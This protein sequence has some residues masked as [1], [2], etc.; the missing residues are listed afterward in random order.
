MR[1]SCGRIYLRSSTAPDWPA[2]LSPRELPAGVTEAISL[3]ACS[4]PRLPAGS[5]V[6]NEALPNTKSPRC[7][8]QKS[9]ILACSSSAPTSPRSTP[10]T[11]ARLEPTKKTLLGWT[12]NR[13]PAGARPASSKRP[14]PSTWLAAYDMERSSAAL[15]H[16]AAGTRARGRAQ[17]P[18]SRGGRER[19]FQLH[20]S[21]AV[22]ANDEPRGRHP[23]HVKGA[24][25][26]PFECGAK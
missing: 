20:V 23:P 12:A 8:I 9:P 19:H 6:S 13:C 21:L 3:P 25:E 10:A 5:D 18:R 24:P 4:A 17:E 2:A 15:R 1:R 11:M 16:S 22:D 7:G 26:R 14:A